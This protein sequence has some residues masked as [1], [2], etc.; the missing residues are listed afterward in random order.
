MGTR[1]TIQ[2]K[3]RYD[4]FHVYRGHDGHP[5]NVVPDIQAVIDKKRNSWSGS[6]TGL[7]VSCFLGE[8]YDKS[9]RLPFYE[10]TSAFH[11]DESYRY[12][13]EYDEDAKEWRVRV[14]G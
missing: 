11:G 5:E 3:D 14:G 9:R 6:E 2:F 1:A 12:F 4:V 13:V 10:M 7:L 8:H